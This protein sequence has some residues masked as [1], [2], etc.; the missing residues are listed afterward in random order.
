MFLR[1]ATARRRIGI[2]AGDLPGITRNVFAWNKVFRRSFY[3]RARIE[4]P[5]G[6]R[7]EDQP[8]TMRAYLLADR[9]DVVARPVYH[10]RVR[11]EGT[12]ITQGRRQLADLHDRLA[13]KSM[14]SQVVRELGDPAVQEFWGRLGVVGDLPVY[15]THIPDFDDEYWRRLVAG[16]RDILHGWPPI[17]DCGLRL[18]QRLIGWLVLHDRRADAERVVSWLAGH[19]GPLRLRVV[20]DRVVP[21]DLPMASD[22]NSDVPDGVRHLGAHEL[23]FDARLVDLAWEGDTL[24]ITGWALV[25]GAP[26][27]GVPTAVRAFLCDRSG[28]TSCVAEVSRFEAPGATTWIDRGDQSYDDS[29]FVARFDL[30]EW[31]ESDRHPDAEPGGHLSVALEVDVASIQRTG[32]L[33]SLTAELDATLPTAVAGPRD[34]AVLWRPGSRLVVERR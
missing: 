12:S 10:W 25:R 24:V 34:V 9:F 15:F 14:V 28:Q 26:T 16:L 6:V 13:T 27:A 32:P 31:L 19:P 5:E 1:D 17:E 3:D 22:P 18:P 21:L 7:Y 4:F 23:E 30:H 11:G 20:D 2:R 8:A 33:R 29:G